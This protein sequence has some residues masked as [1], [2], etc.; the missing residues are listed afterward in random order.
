MTTHDTELG[1][2][3]D[4]G[5]DTGC[6]EYQ[7]LNRRDFLSTTATLTAGGGVLPLVAAAHHARRTT[8]PPRAT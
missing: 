7:Q 8:T 3:L 6:T 4:G 1:P 2:V 5:H